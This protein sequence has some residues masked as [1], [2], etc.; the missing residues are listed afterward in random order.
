MIASLRTTFAWLDLSTR[1]AR[2]AQRQID[3]RYVIPA[4]LQYSLICVY[5][6]RYRAQNRVM[7]SIRA[8]CNTLPVQVYDF[9]RPVPALQHL[10]SY[11]INLHQT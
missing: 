10:L 3:A 11:I 6:Y 5:T 4:I 9:N 2:V 7:K 8:I 1:P